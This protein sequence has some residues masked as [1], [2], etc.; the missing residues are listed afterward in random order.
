MD[1]DFVLDSDAIEVYAFYIRE[2][3]TP[4]ELAQL[5]AGYEN[6]RNFELA[7]AEVAE[8]SPELLIN[9]GLMDDPNAEAV[10]LDQTVVAVAQAYSGPDLA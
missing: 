4:E 7:L 10:D 2:A 6:D 8:E 3:E 5:A 1:N 9:A